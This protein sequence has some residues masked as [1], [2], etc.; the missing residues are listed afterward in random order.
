M[1]RGNLEVQVNPRGPTG[2]ARHGQRLALLHV[3]AARHTGFQA[4]S[5]QVQV[6]RLRPVAVID[7]DEVRVV[8]QQLETAGLVGDAS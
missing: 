1:H 5:R 7:H 6:R 8:S 2:G 4:H 3:G